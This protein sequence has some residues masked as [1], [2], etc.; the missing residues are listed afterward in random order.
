VNDGSRP[1]SLREAIWSRISGPWDLLII[2]GGITGAGILREA[3]RFG[4][5]ALLVERHDFGSGTSS[6][7]SKLVHG[8]LRYLKQGNLR[9]TRESVHERER[10]VREGPGLVER[11]GFV[12]ASYPGEHPGRI[13]YGSGLVVYDVLAG[14]WNH[15]HLS[16]EEVRALAPRISPEGLRGG[17]WFGDAETDDARL[18]FRVIRE[19][20]AGGAAALNY[21]PV[22]ELLMHRGEVA[23]VLV[24]DGLEDRAFEVRARAVI[25]ATGAWADRLRAK[26]GA[27]ARLRP[28]RGSHLVFPAW[29]LPAPQAMSLLHPRD[30][31]PLFV[32]PWEGV[33]IFG[34]TDV[35]HRGPL[36]E[37][38][39][40]GEAEAAYLMEALA[41][42]FPSL[43]LTFR[44]ALATFSGVRPI[45][46][47]GKKDPSK[48]SRDHA[49]WEEHGLVTVTGG[50]LTTFR[51]IALAALRAVRRRFSG[52]VRLDE[53]TSIL[54]SVPE[55]LAVGSALDKGQRRRLLGRYGLEAGQVV[56]SA[57]PG[58]LTPFPSTAVFPAEIRWGARSEW[59]GHLDDLLLRRVRLGLVAARGGAAHLPAIREICRDELGWDEAR[60]AEE[61]RGYLRLWRRQH[62]VPP[63][64]EMEVSS[65]A[66]S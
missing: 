36:D 33:T 35:D 29:R 60:W 18:V 4:L 9:L 63:D 48:E 13:Q 22:E 25:N 61:E 8:G 19:A 21:A 27:T 53:S 16:A 11:L 37:G 66:G 39:A 52:P 46:G 45:I 30:R 28:L 47:T 56:A 7:S 41:A 1:A 2:G 57:R 26:A 15:R 44:D 12:L 10:L 24:K 62:G 14:R 20:V 55:D 40:I 17:F 23:G 51:Q 3:T 54:D 43:D 32:V 59:I 50:K 58:E 31:R 65:W 42:R 64:R 34:T 5:T 38:P 6:R 49:I